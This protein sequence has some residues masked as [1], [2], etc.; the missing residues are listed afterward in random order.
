MKLK[1]EL[2]SNVG[3]NDFKKLW[4]YSVYLF[5][6]GAGHCTAVMYGDYKEKNEAKNA[7]D[8][9]MNH[10]KTKYSHLVDDV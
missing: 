2:N 7:R 3:F 1:Y 6:V 5:E 8:G 10:L 4:F 9:A